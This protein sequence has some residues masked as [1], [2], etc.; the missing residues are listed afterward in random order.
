M[1]ERLSFT[2]ISYPLHPVLNAQNAVALATVVQW[3]WSGQKVRWVTNEN[4]DVLEGTVRSFGD[5][6]GNF[7][8]NSED[9][10]DS[11]LRI[12]TVN[13]FE[14]FMPMQEV[15]DHVRNFTMGAI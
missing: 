7:I 5:E 6:R 1:E 10:R 4:L 2:H 14:V 15:I 11:F 13:G 8:A 12:T 9:V 3:A